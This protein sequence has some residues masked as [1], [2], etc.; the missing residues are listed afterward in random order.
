MYMYVNLFAECPVLPKYICKLF[1][2]GS[3]KKKA[4]PPPLELT[5]HRNFFFKFFL[6]LK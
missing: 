2:K 3:R 5:G 4:L 6:V 1:H